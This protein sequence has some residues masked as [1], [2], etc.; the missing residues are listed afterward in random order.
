MKKS[1]FILATIVVSLSACAD[2]EW[3]ITYAELPE[4][5]Q[6]FIQR[7]YNLVDV[8]Y[9]EQEREGIYFEYNVHLKNATEIDFDHQG[10][11]Q[12]IDCKYSA[13]PADIVPELISDY[14]LS[15]YPN[16]IIVEYTVKRRY[17]K[18]ELSNELDLL[19]NHEGHFLRVDD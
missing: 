16:L 18:I 7:Y 5:A 6:N 2:H 10:N 14:V 19:F 3:M 17:L 13:V 12:S 4:R 1:L 15:H 11:L 8:D 9:I